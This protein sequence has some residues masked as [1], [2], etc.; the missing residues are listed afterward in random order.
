MRAANA[1]RGFTGLE[2]LAAIAVLLA[3]LTVGLLFFWYA[4]SADNGQRRVCLLQL[5][6]IQTAVKNWSAAPNDA[7]VCQTAL[8]LIN[9][10]NNTGRCPELIGRVP[11]PT[12]KQ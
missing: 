7:I 8:N 3:A 1:Q 11:A 10:Y 4:E 5:D 12:C 2:I 6:Q 9:A